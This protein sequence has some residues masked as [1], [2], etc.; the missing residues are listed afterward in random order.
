M[1]ETGAGAGIPRVGR[2]HASVD[3]DEP[4]VVVIK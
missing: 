2:H 1:R 4:L 3:L